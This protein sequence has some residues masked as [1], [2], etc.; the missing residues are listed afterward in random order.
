MYHQVITIALSV[1]GGHHQAIVSGFVPGNYGVQVFPVQ[2]PPDEPQ[3]ER[4]FSLRFSF[5]VG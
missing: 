3:C 4:I 2:L 5:T 1:T